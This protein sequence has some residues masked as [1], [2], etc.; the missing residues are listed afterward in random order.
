[1]LNKKRRTISGSILFRLWVA[2]SSLWVIVSG[3]SSVYSWYQ[4]YRLIGFTDEQGQTT[5]PSYPLQDLWIIFGGPAIFLA[6]GT[7]GLWVARGFR[8]E[9]N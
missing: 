2:I 4:D 9:K 6:L 7:M 5:H 3:S 8:R 1:M